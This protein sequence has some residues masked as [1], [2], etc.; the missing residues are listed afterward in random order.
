MNV[1]GVEN[2]ESVEVFNSAGEV[3]RKF[4]LSAVTSTVQSISLNL[5]SGQS[6]VAA[7]VNPATGATSGGAQLTLTLSNGGTQSLFWDGMGSNGAPLQSGTYLVELVRTEPGPTTTIKTLSVALLQP[8]NGTAQAVAASAKVGPNPVL[9]GEDV[10]VR[11]TPGAGSWVR[12]RLYNESG[13]LV[14]QCRGHGRQRPA[15]LRRR[16]QRRRLPAGL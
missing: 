10:V 6:I 9:K 2:Q 14:A 12:A 5:P 7:S 1:V 13:E 8:K 4:D 3:V 11:Y 16:L 15:D